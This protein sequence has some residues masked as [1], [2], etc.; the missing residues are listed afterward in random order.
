MEYPSVEKSTR[1]YLQQIATV[2][3]EEGSIAKAS[4]AE[5]ENDLDVCFVLFY[6]S[7]S[8]LLSSISYLI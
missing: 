4:G 6:L 5:E 1:E 7:S 8:L 2:I 3:A